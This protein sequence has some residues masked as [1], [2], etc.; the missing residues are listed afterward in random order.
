MLFS[1]LVCKIL[2]NILVLKV[3][4]YQ[5]F[6]IKVNEKKAL[7]KTIN[8]KNIKRVKKGR[9]ARRNIVIITYC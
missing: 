4:K 1:N 6:L 9:K 3:T 5:N 7:K 2:R 8:A